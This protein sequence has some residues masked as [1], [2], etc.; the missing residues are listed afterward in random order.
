MNISE[1][2]KNI[3]QV[4]TSDVRKVRPI[5]NI[6]IERLFNGIGKMDIKLKSV[7]DKIKQ[8]EIDGDIKTKHDLKMKLYYFT[9]CVLVDPNGKRSYKD[10]Q[11]F[12]GL[13]HL[14]FDHIDDSEEFKNY[15]FERYDFIIA[16]WISSSGKGI[17]C[18]VNIPVIEF[19]DYKEGIKEFKS[20]FWGLAK[21]MNQYKGFDPSPQNAVL[22]LFLSPDENILIA[23]KFTIWTKKGTNPNDI[24][25]PTIQYKYD[26]NSDS[27]YKNWSIS[28]IEKAINK[29]TDNGHPQL[30][31]AAYSMGGYVSAG[32][33]SQYE[34]FEVLESFIK[35]NY[36]LSQKANVYIKTSQTMIRKGQQTPIY[37]T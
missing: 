2:N 15:L 6:T 31:A 24:Q 22:P 34:A 33:I 17:K 29:I 7:Y 36:Y 11:Q 32:Y 16:V 27:R 14:D 13:M 19:T 4:F 37:F 28:N 9:P 25:R 35:S 26:Y 30:R 20:Y 3:I 5:G 10:I 8:A 1:I 21:I 12:T 18:L 23:E